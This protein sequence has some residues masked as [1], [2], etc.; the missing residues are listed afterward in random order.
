MQEKNEELEQT[1]SSLVNES[2]MLT[3]DLESAKGRI[4][5]L[6]AEEGRM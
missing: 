1:R 5:E 3:K 2:S 6:M 4:D